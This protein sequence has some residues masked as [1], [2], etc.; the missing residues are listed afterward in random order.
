[1]VGTGTL[2]L[3][4]GTTL[5]NLT[6]DSSN[7]TLAG[8]RDAI[9]KASNNPGVQASIVYG[10]DG[11][12]LSLASKLTGAANTLRIAS[13]DGDGG[14]AQLNYAGTAT[15]NYSVLGAAG[16]AIVTVS[17]IEVHSATNAVSGAIDGVTLNL[18]AADTAQAYSLTVSGD[19]AAVTSSL[20]QFVNAY[21]TQRA[22]IDSLSAYN[23]T[24]K[25]AGPML[26]DPVL[27]AIDAQMRKLSLN[28]V[29]GATG[30]YTSLSSIGIT[31]DINGK[32]SIDSAKLQ[33]AL[34]SQPVAVAQLF[35]G[36][37]GIA[38]RLDTALT[39]LFSTTGQLAARDKSLTADQATLTRQTT[40]LQSRLNTIQQR[41]LAQFTALDTAM[42]QMKQT[43]TYLT[44]QLNA[45]YGTSSTSK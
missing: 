45:L 35:G 42:A 10:Q 33:T 21:N 6:I 17:G 13:S 38:T 30:A 3:T 8:I 22:R 32:L 20:Q 37:N 41:Y 1:V 34:Q 19:P 18:V 26:G 15:P 9:N 7:N 24:T 5:M 36:A 28:Q 12:H 4:L 23:A 40:S 11:A 43:S 27:Q 39:S 16:D 31:S 44:Q 14:L 2:S 29:S 25:V